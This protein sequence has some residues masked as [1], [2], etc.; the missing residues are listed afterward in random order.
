MSRLSPMFLALC[1]LYLM[2]ASAFARQSELT[3]NFPSRLIDAID[4]SALPQGQ[5]ALSAITTP[6]KKSILPPKASAPG[7]D[8]RSDS[9][10]TSKKKSPFRSASSKRF[11]SPPTRRRSIDPMSVY[12]RPTPS[13]LTNPLPDSEVLRPASTP[14]D[15]ERRGSLVTSVVSP[16]SLSQN[17]AGFFEIEIENVSDQIATDIVVQITVP[18]NLTVTE[19]DPAAWMDGELRTLS[20]KIDVIKVGQKEIIRYGAAS[21]ILGSYKQK[22][23]VG[24]N[25]VHQGDTHFKVDVIQ[26]DLNPND[27]FDSPQLKKR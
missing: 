19:V 2:T 25:N 16:A 6:A 21:R 27:A 1:A 5:S 18:K 8:I 7:S 15:I 4:H 20:W 12:K 10:R 13:P 22:I 24:M 3:P 26:N 23:S 11:I 17:S 14:R 9:E